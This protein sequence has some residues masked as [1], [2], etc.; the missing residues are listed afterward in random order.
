MN[1]EQEVGKQ[2]LKKQVSLKKLDADTAKVLFALKEKANKKDLGRKVRD[3]EIIHLGLSL[4]ELSHLEGLRESTYSEQ[5]RLKLAH[6]EYQKQNG[7]L[8]LDQFIGKLLKG[9]IQKNN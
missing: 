9:E 5:D 3:S 8:T 7:K 2:K 4:I 1:Q 6:Q